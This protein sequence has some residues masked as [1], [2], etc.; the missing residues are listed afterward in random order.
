M[1]LADKLSF[2]LPNLLYIDLCEGRE[3]IGSTPRLEYI[4]ITIDKIPIEMRHGTGFFFYTILTSLA[5]VTHLLD[6]VA[7]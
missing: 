4:F 3:D 2:C 1:N 7:S 5:V 6:I